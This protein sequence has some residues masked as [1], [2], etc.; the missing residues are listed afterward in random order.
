[1]KLNS[2]QSFW[3]TL[4]IILGFISLFTTDS[5]SGLIIL[6]SITLIVILLQNSTNAVLLFLIACAIYNPS[7]D[8][9]NLYIQDKLS[10]NEEVLKIE[11]SDWVIFSFYDVKI[12]QENPFKVKQILVDN[13]LSAMNIIKTLNNSE[14]LNHT[15]AELA[16]ENSQ[17][18]L[19]ENITFLPELER[20]SSTLKPNEFTFKPIQTQY[21]Y[22][23]LYI[24]DKKEKQIHHKTYLGVLKN[25]W[26]T[27]TPDPIISL[28][29][30]IVYIIDKSAKTFADK[31]YNTF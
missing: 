5:Y 13:N 4:A 26:D 14:D 29:A 25:F 20:V 10:S 1:M 30:Y 27:Y 3:L 16:K 8:K 12:Q 24:E 18:M 31:V 22:H 7:T 6:V 17:N 21:G 28:M 11:K 2:E 19:N 23:I 9:F 15:F